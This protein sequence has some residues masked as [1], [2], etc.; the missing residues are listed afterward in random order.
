MRHDRGPVGRNLATAIREA[1]G[2]AAPIGLSINLSAVDLCRSSTPLTILSL[3]RHYGFD[4][5]RLEL[6]VTETSVLSDFD[7]A[8]DQLELLRRSGIRVSLDDF[9]SGFASISYLKE[10]TFDRVKI[11]GELIADIITS[12]KARRLVQGILQLCSAINVPTTA[13]KV[14]CN[15]QLAVLV[16]LGCDRLQGYL[17]GH[18]VSANAAR[19]LAGIRL[20]AA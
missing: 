3:C 1:A 2:W 9:G 13:E 5:G 15:D 11:D 6:E 10:I 16:G 4:P 7:V 14:E 12:A 18:P 20:K 8:R 19:R 17:L